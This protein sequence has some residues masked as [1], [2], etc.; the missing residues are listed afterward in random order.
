[1]AVVEYFIESLDAEPS[2]GHALVIQWGR[3]LRRRR[4][5]RWHSLLRAL[6]LLLLV[7]R[8]RT[9][10]CEHATPLTTSW[11]TRTAADFDAVRARHRAAAALR[12][13]ALGARLAAHD[14]R[15]RAGARDVAVT[16]TRD[17]AAA[18]AGAR[19]AAVRT[20]VDDALAR[21]GACDETVAAADEVAVAGACTL[22]VARAAAVDETVACTRA[23]AARTRA[24]D[25]AFDVVATACRGDRY[26]QEH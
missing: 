6:D 4:W 3:Q 14:A 8:A 17:I 20:H 22:Q 2:L 26:Q 5:W 9:S 16:V 21:A 15:A 11:R 1:M 7:A 12:D 18:R 10:T 19:D 23:D 25:V 24:L 13:R